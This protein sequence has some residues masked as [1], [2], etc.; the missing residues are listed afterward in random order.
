MAGEPGLWFA[1]FDEYRRIGTNRTV[2]EAF[3]RCAEREGLKGLR[4]GQA[5]YEAARAW[6]WAERAAAW[7]AAQ[8]VEL[9][10]REQDR[11]FDARERRLGVIDRLLEAAVGVIALADLPHLTDI[12]ARQ[13]LPTMRLLVRDMLQAERAELGSPAAAG[14]ENPQVAAFSADEMAAAARAAREFE[15]VLAASGGEGGERVSEV[16]VLQGGPGVLLVV[17]GADAALRV[18]L[19]ALRSVKA[20]AGLAFHRLN[21]ATREAVDR[22]LRRERSN[23]RGVRWV[24]MAVHASPEG[25]LLADGQVNGDWLSERLLGVQVLVL[26]GCNGDQVGDW[27]GVVPHVVTLG[28]EIGHG[29]AA[30]LTEQFWL[31]MARGAEPARALEMALE[32]CAPAVSE[33][34]VRHW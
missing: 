33:Y 6:R 16:G 32:R 13:W 27:L 25:V 11:R 12:E 34:V 29:D 7:D 4:P 22:Y 23:G 17:V 26:A 30:T 9:M 2:D 3:R 28:E 1:R 19:A 21:N 20:Q 15:A 5:W 31:Q 18:D 10:A 14:A 24:H 8:R